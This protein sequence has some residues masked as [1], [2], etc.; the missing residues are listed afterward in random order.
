MEAIRTHAEVAD[1]L[2]QR[3][4]CRIS[5]QRVWQIEQKALEKL[6]ER[7]AKV[8]AEHWQHDREKT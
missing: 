8:A 6:R 5:K 3:G 1:L 4:I 2:A 7:L